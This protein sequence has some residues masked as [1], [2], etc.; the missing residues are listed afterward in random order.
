MSQG[1][2]SNP[3]PYREEDRQIEQ[4]FRQVTGQAPAPQRPAPVSPEEAQIEQTIRQIQQEQRTASEPVAPEAPTAHIPVSQIPVQQPVSRNVHP[5]V[6]S[7]AP[8]RLPK[9]D[10][11]PD[12]VDA[13][14]NGT[15]PVFP[16]ETY[17][18]EP[19]F[20]DK[21]LDFFRR[22]RTKVLAGAC[23]AALLLIVAFIAAFFTGTKVETDNGKILNNVYIADINVGGMTKAEAANLV[24]QVAGTTYPSLDMIIDLSGTELRLSPKD[25]DAKLDIE[26]AV[27]AAYDYGRTGTKSEQEQAKNQSAT[28]QHIIG[29]LPYL[30]LDTRYIRDFLTDYASDSGST[31]TQPT[32]GLEGRAPELSTDK[33][34]EKAPTQTL[35]ITLG[36][37]GIGF[38]VNEVYDMVLDAYSLHQFMVTVENVT[39]TKEPD[40]V[41]LEA[42]YEEFYIK[43]V[44]ATVNLQTFETEPGSYGYGFDIKEAQKLIDKAEYG[45]EVR[46]PME[47]IEPDVL[48][49]DNFFQDNLG[50]YQTRTTGNDDRNENMKLAC[51]AIHDT[52]LDP[53]ETLSFSDALSRVSGF[54]TAPEDTGK[55]AADRGGVTQVSST[56]YYAALVSD[57]EIVARSNHSY[58]PSYIEQGMDATA[59]LQI[60]NST[61]YPIRIDAKLSGSYVKIKIIGTEE[62]EH[63]VALDYS[64]ANTYTPVTEYKDF[65]YDNAEGYKDGDVIQEGLTGYLVKTYKIK[66]DIASGKELSRDFV[67]N[68]QYPS[69]NKIVARVEAEPVTEP[70]TIPTEPPTEAT[71]PPETQATEPAPQPTE[72]PATQP[73]TVTEPQEAD[74]VLETTPA[75]IVPVG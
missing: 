4:A 32:Y 10:L 37:P 27:N 26:A 57:L 34:D 46:I 29:L 30:E 51:M 64:L 55:E 28:R 43:P 36:S 22:N 24:K 9:Q 68:S 18:P 15:T 75:E 65:P 52:V 33:F 53:G 2:F 63:Y 31:L 47:Y 40:P 72:P 74:P 23:A 20:L 67:T 71:R 11:L 7:S 42:I 45:E 1:K 3:R 41:D 58:I 19:D 38:D 39:S 8:V 66:Y 61:G 17:E 49:A 16:E 48:E 21:A 59:D 12:D 60:R 73:V 62:R 70:P 50:E 13:F 54:K 25:T 44:D 69:L 56:L 14:F 5:P 35:V 6:R